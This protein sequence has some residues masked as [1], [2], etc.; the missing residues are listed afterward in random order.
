VGERTWRA[1]AFEKGVDAWI[2]TWNRMAPNTIPAMARIAG[3]YLSGQLIKME[4]LANG[5]AEAIALGPD[6]H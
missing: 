1:G 4:A 5:F 6:G 2:S 3:N